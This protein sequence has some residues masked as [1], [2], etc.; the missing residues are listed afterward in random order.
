MNLL[1]SLIN[2]ENSIQ[3]ILSDSEK[4]KQFLPILYNLANT[5]KKEDEYSICALV[6]FEENKDGDLAPILRV[7]STKIIGTENE[8]QIIVN[9]NINGVNGEPLKF[10]L[11]EMLIAHN[12]NEEKETK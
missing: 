4:V 8:K 2:G 5:Y 3:E 7:V 6:S 11:L 1:N 9:R 10:N 12:T